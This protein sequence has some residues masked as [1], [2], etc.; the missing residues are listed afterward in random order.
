M[1]G[2]DLNSIMG[3]TVGQYTLGVLLKAVLAA[4]ICYAAIR[5]LRR[6]VARLLGG[7]RMNDRVRKYVLTAINVVLWVIGIIIVADCLGINMTSLV[8]LLSVGSLGLTLAAEDILGN[9]AGGLVILSSHLFSLDDFIQVGETSGY[10]REI[11]LNHTKIA[12]LDGLMV[13]LPNK[14]VASSEVRNYTAL[15]LR[16]VRRDVTASYNARTEDVKAACRDALA[17]VGNIVSEPAPSVYLSDYGSS[18]IEYSIFCWTKP[19][20]YWQVYYELGETL[21]DTFAK[22]GV[23]M[24]YD[25]LNV[26]M[27]GE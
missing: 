9:V 3:T 4:V 12:T 27:V 16:R 22:H 6:V 1:D 18:S 11:S 13:L 14:S 25:H 8:A 5:L 7:T 20:N 17:E 23:E 26:H 15:G 24:T 19:E 10:V 2:I 21:R